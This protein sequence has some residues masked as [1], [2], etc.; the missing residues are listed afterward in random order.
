M[1]LRSLRKQVERLRPPSEPEPL[2]VMVVRRVLR[3]GGEPGPVW[4]CGIGFPRQRFDT[5]EEA[6][7]AIAAYRG[8]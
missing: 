1:N 6:R 5:M 3:P 2:S 7:V 4:V 8:E